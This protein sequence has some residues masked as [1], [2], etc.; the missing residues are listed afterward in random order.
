MN[1]K[2]LSTETRNPDTS[3]IDRL[4]T[5]EMVR[6]INTEDKKV[7]LAVEAQLPN[8]ARAVDAIAER[9]A[10]GGRLLYAGAGTSGRLGVL[11]ASECPPTFG[12]PQ[13]MVCAVI[14]GGQEAV[15]HAVEG[16]EDD[17]A[18]GAADMKAVLS[19]GDVLVGIAASGRTPYVLGAMGQA[20]EAGA[21][22][23]A[24]VCNAGSPMAQIA[25]IAIEA[26]VG[27]E[28]ITGSTRMKAGT[29]QKMVLNM[30]S[31]ATM[32]R[33]GKVYGNLMVDLQASNEKLNDRAVR[34]VTE[35]A[36][37]DSQSAAEAL[38]HCGG[39]AKTAICVLRCGI[40]PDE[41]RELL[42]RHGGVLARALAEK[43]QA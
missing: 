2:E 13:S 40:Q 4:S 22:V 23:I 8:I 43:G 37:V 3:G 18:Q 30:L 42:A 20:R 9:L 36:G 5:L 35:A 33:L 32:V 1:L 19:K 26:I 34:I 16:A 25:D 41:A 11:D 6:A 15:F 21:V 31:T 17:A 39:E 28:A 29:A 14:A 27:P 38:S 7:A 12:V 10:H 24:L